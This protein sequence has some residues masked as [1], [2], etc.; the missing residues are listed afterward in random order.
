MCSAN[1]I[2]CGCINM[3][4]IYLPKFPRTMIFFPAFGIKV[5]FY[6]KYAIFKH[7]S[8]S[9]V[10][11]AVGLPPGF[12]TTPYERVWPTKNFTGSSFGLPFSNAD[13][14][15]L[16]HPAMENKTLAEIISCKMRIDLICNHLSCHEV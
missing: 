7:T 8:V 4:L 9:V 6:V 14:F 2:I 1:D 5:L 16:A 10:M 13:G 15:I 11:R 3:V 12:S